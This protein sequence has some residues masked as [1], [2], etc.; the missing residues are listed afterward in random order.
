MEEPLSVAK[1]PPEPKEARPNTGA[2]ASGVLPAET[3]PKV[4]EAAELPDPDTTPPNRPGFAGAAVVRFPKRPAPFVGGLPARTEV[5][6]AVVD[7][8][9]PQLDVGSAGCGAG[10][11]ADTGTPFGGGR[12]GVTDGEGDAAPSH[13]K[14]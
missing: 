6:R 14:D 2:P 12:A 3:F 8:P 5:G 11:V 4:V 10:S 1:N 9:S 13:K 7:V